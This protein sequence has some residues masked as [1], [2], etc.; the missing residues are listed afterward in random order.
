MINKT[1][2]LAIHRHENIRLAWKHGFKIAQGRFGLAKYATQ[3]VLV[4]FYWSILSINKQIFDK[5]T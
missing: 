5:G 4:V 1:C 3:N 2:L